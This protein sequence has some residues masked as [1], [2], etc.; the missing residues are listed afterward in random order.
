EETRARF[1]FCVLLDCHS[2]PSLREL[3][4][5]A[6]G[7][8]AEMVLGDGHGTTAAGALLDIAARSLAAEG[9]RISFNAPYAGGFV[10]RHYG[11][12]EHGVHAV[13]LEIARRLYMEEG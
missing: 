7:G 1:G 10:T 9:F 2:M 12:P 13:Q 4:D 11:R 8:N 6:A 3:A 5:Q